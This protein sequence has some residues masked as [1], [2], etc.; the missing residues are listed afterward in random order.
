MMRARP[1]TCPTRLS[2]AGG[3]NGRLP[4]LTA[5]HAPET[6][7]AGRVM[8]AREPI[9]PHLA[10]AR[11]SPDHRSAFWKTRN[12]PVLCVDTVSYTH[13]RAHETVLDLV[14]RLLLE[15]KKKKRI[16]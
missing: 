3:V 14:C 2:S 8:P 10:T 12:L 7:S 11:L 15:K 5:D 4:R 1:M 6:T 16:E 13:L 9:P